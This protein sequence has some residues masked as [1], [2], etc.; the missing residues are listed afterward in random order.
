MVVFR[1]LALMCARPAAPRLQLSYLGGLPAMYC[2]NL[3]WFSKVV[4]A[5]R[6]TLAK[7]DDK[8]EKSA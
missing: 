6:R 4:D 7:G 3:W 2:L 5:A 1:R 8:A